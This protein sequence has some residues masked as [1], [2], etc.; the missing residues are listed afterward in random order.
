MV[1][2]IITAYRAQIY[3]LTFADVWRI[4]KG[5]KKLF[6]LV[7][8]GLLAIGF[9]IAMGLISGHYCLTIIAFSLE[10][11]A[12][13]AA[14]RYAVKEYRK[15]L[16][17]REEHLEMVKEFLKTAICGINLYNP[18]QIAGLVDRL[19]KR[20]EEK[21]PFYRTSLR[22]KNFASVVIIPIIT[23]IAGAFSG[24][25]QQMEFSDVLLFGIGI[26]IALATIWL[27]GTMLLD[28]LRLVFCRDFDAAVSLREDLLD[29]QLLQ[30]PAKCNQT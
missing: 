14:D 30:F 16:S 4:Y 10:V 5:N 12:M 29:L 23:Y 17:A 8:G 18:E 27:V 19:S 1:D 24:N 7:F 6:L 26:I 11:I 22:L 21:R 9:L 13:V 15:A 25:L 3:D 2:R 28:F 20:V